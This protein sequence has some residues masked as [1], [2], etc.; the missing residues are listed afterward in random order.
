MRCIVGLLPTLGATVVG[1]AAGGFLGG[2]T[3]AVTLFL[4]SASLIQASR[5]WPPG[6]LPAP[7]LGS[8]QLL[9]TIVGAVLGAW[10][11]GWLGALAGFLLATVL[12][13]ITNHAIALF[14]SGGRSGP[15]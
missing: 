13:M 7:I 10:P 12:G 9:A 11:L 2:L 15:N 3:G 14:Q 6:F 5:P 8:L 1:W 4:V